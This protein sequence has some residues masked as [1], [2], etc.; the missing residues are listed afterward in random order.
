MSTQLPLNA[1]TRVRILTALT[2]LSGCCALAY[3]VL[4]LRALTTLLGDMLYVHAALLSTF[5]V[6][7]ALGA[8]LAD[9][10]VRWLWL[11]EVLTGVY[12]LALPALTRWLAGQPVL[13]TISSRPSLTIVMTIALLTIPSLMI[14]FS[15]PLFSAYI[16]NIVVQR[17]AFQRIY[18]AYNLG[19]LLSVLAVELLMVRHL[20]VTLSLGTIGGINLFNGAVLWWM[21]AAPDHAPE[22]QRRRF[23]GRVIVALAMIS[24]ASAAFQ[25][26][27]LKL[28]YLVFGP[29]RE[30]FAVGL[31]VTLLGIFA[32][33]WVASRVRWRFETFL[34]LVPLTVGLTYAAY[35]PLVEFH[36]ATRGWFQGSELLVLVH[37]F[38]IG[39]LF[40]L[41]PMILFGATLPALMR[42]E[43]EV[44]GESGHLLWISSLANAGGYLFYVLVGHPLLDT[45]VL[46]AGIAALALAGSLL[47]SGFSWT[48]PQWITAA[49]GTLAVLL[50]LVTWEERDFYLAQWVGL[51]D[52]DETVTVYKSGAESA[53]LIADDEDEWVTYN[54]HPS[55]TVMDDGIVTVSETISG[56]IP[57]LAAPSLERALV[58][59]LGTGITGGASAGVFDHTDVVEIN[60]A[61]YRMMPRLSHANLDVGTNPAASLHLADGRAFLVGKV[62]AYDAILNSIPAP[63][64]YSASKIYTVEFYR[65]VAEALKPGGVFCSW[66][67]SENMSEDGLEV[68][69]SAMY[70]SFPYCDLRLIG[71]G[72]YMATCSA[73]PIKLRG[74]RDLPVQLDVIDQLQLGLP[75]FDLTEYFEDIRISDNIFENFT[76]RVPQENT[77]DHPVLEFM[78]VRNYQLGQMGDDPFLTRQREMNVDP[79]RLDGIEDPFRFARR[80]RAFYEMGADQYRANFLPI[81]KDTPELWERWRSAG[82]DDDPNR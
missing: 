28:T 51:L 30:N 17:L 41:P 78:V 45:H 47:A 4:Y 24:L 26:F 59:G 37:K 49:A 50:M 75:D 53:T 66:L 22:V 40:A 82:L 62:R 21:R 16:K 33:A 42:S 60:N 77:D 72:Y 69:L 81:L 74:F 15:I 10:Y 54:G 11:L 9:R 7:I 52:G 46:L 36:E 25:M 29:H 27:F 73:E 5:L 44:A 8:K 13:S 61:F 68:V 23:A 34:L 70:Q 3:E 18:M 55:I 31:S 12:A 71:R 79:V 2:L 64:Y 6:G 1:S 48:K 63:T 35:L 56:V 39:S 67:A 20:G 76:P 65:R 38:A 57:A 58:L 19:A 43:R 80:A 32:G 14:G